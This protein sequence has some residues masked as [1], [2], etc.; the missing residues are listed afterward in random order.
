MEIMLIKKIVLTGPE[1]TGKSTLT[2]QLSEYYKM[3]MIS[4]I[5]RNYV[6]NLNRP[7]TQKDV[8]EIAKLQINAEQKIIKQQPEIIFL[9]TDLIITKIWLIH[10]YSDCPMF[11]DKHLREN[12]AHLHLLCYYDIQWEYDSVRENPDL[13]EYFFDKY[14]DEIKFYSLNYK[15][16]KGTGEK[17][18]ENAV[19]LI[20]MHSCC[21]SQK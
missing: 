15:I 8:V 11:V 6:A 20:N 13:R 17:R 19:K 21:M 14:L 4:E 10:R 12:P 7:Y 1:S 5:A 16:I 3:P 9:D 18:F 2:K